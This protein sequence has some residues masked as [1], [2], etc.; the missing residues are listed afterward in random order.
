MPNPIRTQRD[1]TWEANFV[2][3]PAFPPGYYFAQKSGGD[4]AAEFTKV[5]D[6]GQLVPEV[7]FMEANTSDITLVGLYR[8]QDHQAILRTLR[9]NVGKV[10][11]NLVRLDRD[12]NMQVIGDG[13]PFNGCLLVGIKDPEFDSN[14]STEARFELTFSVPA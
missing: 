5:R 11:A 1:Q 6:G 9:A 3:V 14:S 10:T 8:A 13:E 7:L 2:G 4:K 12:Q